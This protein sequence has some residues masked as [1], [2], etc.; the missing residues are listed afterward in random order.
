MLP[1]AFA[2]ALLCVASLA[3]AQDGLLIGGQYVS[4]SRAFGEVLGPAPLL[5]QQQLFGGGRYALMGDTVFDGRSGQAVYATPDLVLA[6]DLARPRLFE[7]R[8]DGVWMVNA[9]THLAYNV[10]AA[11]GTAVRRCAFAY[12]ADVLYCLVDRADELSDV[13]AVN[14]AIGPARTVASLDLSRPLPFGQIA[15]WLVTPDGERI[16]FGDGQPQSALAVL[17]VATGR[18]TNSDAPGGASGYPGSQRPGLP[19]WD[20]A[21]ERVIVHGFG[22]LWVLDKYLRPIIAGAAV[23]GECTDI[24]V[25]AHTGRMYAYQYASQ[26]GYGQAEMWETLRVL[27]S[28]TFV[29]LAAPVFRRRP[30]VVGCQFMAVLT[31]PG[32]PRN[33]AVSVNGS[34]VSLA[35]T[36]VGAASHFVLD[37][38]FAPGRTDAS[39]FLGPDSHAAFANVPPGIYYLRLRGGNEFGGGRPSQ[40]IQVIVP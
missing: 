39:V 13:V 26:Y 20:D 24:Q 29:P 1:I 8:S 6:L 32:V 25:S 4:A 18:V 2:L 17:D 5:G 12:S 28:S 3:S 19:S 36:N 7:R 33:V 21:N 35:W 40:E 15:A 9:Q 27:D 38:G 34:D 10:L 14:L 37:V 31:A 16:Y 22:T 11:V 30:R 23:G